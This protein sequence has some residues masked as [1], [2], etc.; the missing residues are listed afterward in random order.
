[1][2]LITGTGPDNTEESLDPAQVAHQ[3]VVAE[4]EQFAWDDL[5]GAVSGT[6]GAPTDTNVLIAMT[7]AVFAVAKPLWTEREKIAT[8]AGVEAAAITAVVAQPHL[9]RNEAVNLV[10]SMLH[11]GNPRHREHAEQIVDDAWQIGAPSPVTVPAPAKTPRSAPRHHPHPWGDIPGV[12]VF[13]GIIED[14]RTSPAGEDAPGEVLP[15]GHMAKVLAFPSR[16]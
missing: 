9:S 1:M 3:A 8:D 2:H 10:L 16:H 7:D 15:E 12:D 5:Y 14:D 4:W 11:G 13:P 6:P